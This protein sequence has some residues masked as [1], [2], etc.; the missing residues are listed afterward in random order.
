MPC[1]HHPLKLQ[2][3]QNKFLL[4]TDNFARCTPVHDLHVPFKISHVYYFVIKL[5]RQQERRKIIIKKFV[6]Q[7]KA[8]P[9]TE[10]SGTIGCYRSARAVC[11]LSAPPEARPLTFLLVYDGTQIRSSRVE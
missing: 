7:A 3:L 6:L 10:R 5:C 2:R 11:R 1:K 9:S 8:K 4:A